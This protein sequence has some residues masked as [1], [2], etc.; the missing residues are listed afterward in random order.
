MWPM[1][2]KSRL[3]EL[4]ALLP[5]IRNILH[6]NRGQNAVILAEVVRGFFI[7]GNLNQ[8]ALRTHV[9]VINAL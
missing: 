5:C 6:S 1:Y 2:T 3:I 9:T 4:E 8:K 7:H